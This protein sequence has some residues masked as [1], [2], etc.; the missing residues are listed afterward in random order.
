MLYK[1]DHVLDYVDAYLHDALPSYEK[2]FVEHHC[3]TCLICRTALDEARKRLA[4]LQSVPPAEASAALILA[5][6]QKIGAYRAPRLT[7]RRVGWSSLAAAALFLVAVHVYYASLAPTPYELAVLGQTQLIAG[8]EG[9]LRVLLVDH[10]TRQPLAGTPVEIELADKA[11][12]A[13]VR[14]AR[15]TTDAFGSGQPRFRLP[16]WSDGAYELRVRARPGWSAE[17]IAREVKLHRSWQLMLS[18]DKP[19]YQPGQTIRLRSLALARPDLKPVAGQAVSYTVADP[20]GNLIFRTRDV[21]SRFG[22]ASADC[23]LAEEIAEGGYR[24]ECRLGDTTSA[25]TVEVRKYVLPKFKIDLSLD[26]PYYQPGQKLRGTL[27]V[28]YF[29]GKPVAG[30]EVEIE[31]QWPRHRPIH[32]GYAPRADRPARYCPIRNHVPDVAGRPAASQVAD[33]EIG[34]LVSVQDSAAEAIQERH[35]G[36]HHAP[37]PRGNHSRGRPTGARGGQHHLPLHHLSRRPARSHA[38]CNHRVGPRVEDQ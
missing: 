24:V 14:L 36:G 26:E 10:Y 31:L 37:D 4:V 11:H 16:Q 32:L 21:T 28:R 15:F 3:Q 12:G 30:A 25:A 18:T 35:A 38:D 13:V 22:I 33:G 20:K 2:R 8:S 1:G 23:P 19:V 17:T 5:T 27:D 29:F 6:E 7:L 34:V 9:S